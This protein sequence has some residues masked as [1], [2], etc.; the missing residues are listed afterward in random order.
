MA[1]SLFSASASSRWINCPGSLTLNKDIPSTTNPA[2]REGTAL[3]ELSDRCLQDGSN[4]VDHEGETIEVE[5]DIF[6]LDEEQ[7]LASQQYVDY[8]RSIE[9]ERWAES[10]IYYANILGL[11]DDSEAFGTVDC[12][13][14][15]GETLH[16]IDAK[17]GRRFVDPKN[18]RQMTLYALGLVDAMEA[19]GIAINEVHLHIVQ[20]RVSSNPIPFVMTRHDLEVA[21]VDFQFA[22]ERAKKASA[23][24]RPK[25]FDLKWISEYLI[26]GESQCQWCPSASI[27]P[28]LAEVV[29]N[30]DFTGSGDV[31]HRQ[32]AQELAENHRKIPL[33]KIWIDA[34]DTEMMSRLN[35]GKEVPGYKLVLGREGNRKWTDVDQAEAELTALLAEHPDAD[36]ELYKPSVLVTAPQAEK[37][38]KKAKIPTEIIDTLV[39]RAPAKPTIATFDDPRPAWVEDA[40]EFDVVE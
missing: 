31:Y 37:A 35:E 5:N 36:V 21:L 11:E 38:L 19:V 30:V 1:H 6:V 28:A 14:L 3:H 4:P 24:F 26:P 13:I 34:V 12:A 40:L 32:S 8:V 20:P 22:V 39:S 2:A 16:V 17:F 9:G 23:E 18:N 33:L 25:E 29:N 10:R 7:C 27:C 15:S